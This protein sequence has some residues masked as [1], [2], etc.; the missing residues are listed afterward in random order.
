VD[1]ADELA[2]ADLEAIEADVALQAAPR[3]GLNVLYIGFTNT[4]APF[5]NVR[6]RK[7]IALG[8]DRARVVRELYP[9][10]SEVASYLAPC[11]IPDGCAGDPWYEFDPAAARQ[12][13]AD[14]GFRDGFRTTIQYRTAPRSYLPDPTAV[15]TENQS[16]LLANL[17]IEAELQVL[18]D[19][20]FLSTV[21]AGQ[22]DGIN[23]LGRTLSV[24]EISSLLNPHFGVAASR[25]FGDPINGLA[26]LITTGATTQEQDIRSTTY[27]EANNLIRADVPLI[28]IVHA[29]S[30]TAYRWDVGGVAASP[31]GLERFASLTTGDRSQL[32]WL[33]RQGIDGLYCADETTSTA[34][35]ACA[36]L[37]E[38]LFGFVEGA[39]GVRPLLAEGCEPNAELTVW[40]CTLRQ[41]VRFHDGSVLDANDVVL[42]F[43]VQW[44]ADHP[45]HRGRE[46]TFQ[47][48]ADAFGGLLNPPRE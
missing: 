34:E 5:D 1:A 47:P 22:A 39:A 9:A 44:D 6:V 12:M 28:P 16:Q 17:N 27:A 24:P 19:D 21:D 42:S 18:P 3:P 43:A 38:G 40:R 7:A 25:E 2:T 48:F 4:F 31:V 20:T 15:A 30:L 46:G 37:T 10:G 35:L 13:L 23:L 36:Q 26:D 32:V 41:D 8:I 45:L 29:G 33:A 14:A 11:S